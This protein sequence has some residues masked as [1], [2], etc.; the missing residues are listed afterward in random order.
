MKQSWLYVK[1]N[2]IDK[3]SAKVTRWKKEKTQI[4][5]ISAE[6]EATVKDTTKI[7]RSFKEYFLKL[8]YNK[9]ERQE[10]M[11]TLLDTVDH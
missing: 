6:N 3:Q 2:K 10:E 9:L 8:Y 7:Q 11:D 5:K 4:I 1:I